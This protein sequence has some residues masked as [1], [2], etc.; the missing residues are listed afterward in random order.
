MATDP[1][2]ECAERPSPAAVS[3]ASPVDD[4]GLRPG[5]AALAYLMLVMAMLAWA[6]NFV[7]ARLAAPEIPAFGLSL[8]RWLVAFAVV[9]PFTAREIIAKRAAILRDWRI[10]LLLGLTGTTASNSLAYLGIARTTV[11]N[12]GLVNSASPMLML[13]ASFTLF[14]ERAQPRQLG[15]IL[16]SLC[17]VAV[18][19]LRGDLWALGQLSLNLGDLEILLGVVAWSIYSVLLRQRPPELSPLALLCVLFAVGAASLLPLHLLVDISR[20]RRSALISSSAWCRRSAPSC[21]GTGR[22][23][24]SGPTGPASSTI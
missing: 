23:H 8:M 24:S 14:R 4:L 1:K 9:L 7:V 22:W 5:M 13:L 15:G 12:A 2:S 17:G 20:R 19:L 6:G 3:A 10:L 11:I 21:G 18:I 16:I